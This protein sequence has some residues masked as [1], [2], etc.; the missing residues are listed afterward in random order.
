VPRGMQAPK[1][2]EPYRNRPMHQADPATA[3]S[4][5]GCDPIKAAPN[6]WNPTSV[7]RRT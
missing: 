6:G 7:G 3:A 5:D 1:V 2:A 4:Q